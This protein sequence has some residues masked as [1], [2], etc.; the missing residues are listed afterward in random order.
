MGQGFGQWGWRAGASLLALSATPAWADEQTG[1]ASSGT[2]ERGEIV[3]YG[4]RQQDVFAGLMAETELDENDIAAYGFDTISDLLNE[5]AGE[6]DAS[7]DGPVVLINGQLTNGINDIADL[8]TEAATRVQILPTAAAARLG[9]SPS[10]RVINLVI[11]PNL[12]QY[13]GSAQAA[14]STRGDSFRGEAEL[15]LLKLVENNR[16][17]L[18]L[19]AQRVDPLFESERHIRPDISGIPYD[20]AGNVVGLG[21]V[22]SEIDPALSTLAGITVTAAGTQPGVLVPTLAS[23]VPFANIPRLAG[24]GFAR[25]LFDSQNVYSANANI[26]QR[27]GPRTTLALTA[28][29]EQSEGEGFSG[30][31]PALVTLSPTSPFWPFGRNVGVAY[32]VGERCAATIGRLRLPSARLLVAEPVTLCSRRAQTSFIVSAGPKA[33]AITTLLHCRPRWQQA[34]PAPS[35]RSI[36]HCSVAYAPTYRKAAATTAISRQ[37]QAAP[38]SNFPP[39]KCG[40]P[41]VLGGGSTD[42]PPPH[43]ER[44]LTATIVSVAAKWAHKRTSRFLCCRGEESTSARSRQISPRESAT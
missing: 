43:V 37:R 36:R 9:Q 40:F 15:N 3:V 32:L 34:Q 24:A 39:A 33:T 5:I 42:F 44:A 21:A 26:T 29:L 12:N 23:F 25:T 11:K 10:R 28:R 14:L 27:F 38:C 4:E 8:P 19:K 41:R 6:V 35:L 7:G 13:T 17:S 1:G 31:A 20:V 22:G 18:V 16:R 30:L 2:P